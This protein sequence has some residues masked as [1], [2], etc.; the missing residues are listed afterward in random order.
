[1]QNNTQ[2]LKPIC[3]IVTR[4]SHFWH[5]YTPPHVADVTTCQWIPVTLLDVGSR[6]LI[7]KLTNNALVQVFIT[8]ICWLIQRSALNFCIRL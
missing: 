2:T 3:K 6:I 8:V 5:V 1:M 4:V 7:T